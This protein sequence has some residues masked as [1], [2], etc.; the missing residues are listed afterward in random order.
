VFKDAERDGSKWVQDWREEQS[1][2]NLWKKISQ[3]N[4]EKR[5]KWDIDKE[6]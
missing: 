1:S 6:A 2:F 5:V 3:R 4:F